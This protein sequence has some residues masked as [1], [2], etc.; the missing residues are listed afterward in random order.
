MDGVYQY[1][2]NL[3]EAEVKL[4]NEARKAVNPFAEGTKCIVRILYDSNGYPINYYFDEL[5]DYCRQQYLDDYG[6][7]QLISEFTK[8][9]FDTAANYVCVL[10]HLKRGDFN[11]VT[12]A[13]L[14]LPPYP[15][16]PVRPRIPIKYR[17]ECCGEFTQNEPV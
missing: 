11:Y 13:F 8:M 6:E 10:D 15:Q 2:Y 16:T 14:S 17:H 4:Y 1:A 12:P 5:I 3:N 7:R 9:D